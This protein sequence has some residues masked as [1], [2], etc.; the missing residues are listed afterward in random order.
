VQE[1]TEIVHFEPAPEQRRVMLVDISDTHGGNRFGL[2]N[3][4]TVLVDEDPLS[5]M[6]NKLPVQL[7]ASQQFIWEAYSANMQAVQDAAGED[8]IIVI[9]NGDATQGDK[10]PELL[11]SNRKSDQ[12]LI[13]RDN[14]APWLEIP[15]VKAMRIV[16][17]TEAHNMGK[18][19]AEYLLAELL[20]KQYPHK[21]I[22]AVY[23]DLI[24]ID[25]YIVDTS[26]HGPNQSVRF[27]LNGNTARYYLQDLML[28]SIMAGNKPPDLVLRAHFHTWINE[29]VSVVVENVEY[30]SRIIVTPSHCMIGDYV[31][32]ALRSLAGIQVGGAAFEI[33]GGQCHKVHRLVKTLDVRMRERL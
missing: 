18:G 31:R 27:W 24:D 12:I 8:E 32:Q 16:I 9:H 17:G 7:N 23:H 20:A 26:H 33:V 29:V 5:G 4:A 6:V 22:Q 10:H 13:A 3:P 11:V 14:L 19:M 30:T 21:D 25:G 1:Q 2:L 28:R 15:N